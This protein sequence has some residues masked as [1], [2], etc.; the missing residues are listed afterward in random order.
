MK[1]L[2]VVCL[3]AS[4]AFSALAEDVS[5]VLEPD[6]AGICFAISNSCVREENSGN[7][8]MAIAATKLKH[9][10]SAD[11]LLK[12]FRQC[13][14]GLGDTPR[15]AVACER[16]V[17][18]MSGLCGT[19]ALPYVEHLVESDK[20]DG[21]AC[22][23][24]RQLIR[25]ERNLDRLLLFA[26]KLLDSGAGRGDSARIALYR[27]LRKLWKQA[28]DGGDH[29][30]KAKLASFFARRESL[31]KDFEHL[32]P[33]DFLAARRDAVKVDGLDWAGICFAISNSCVG[34]RHPEDAWMTIAA[35]KVKYK[36][37]EDQMLEAF[38]RCIEGLG[39]TLNETMACERIVHCMS[40]DCGTNALP[41]VEYLIEND[42][43]DGVVACAY[44]ELVKMEPSMDKKLLYAEKVLDLKS[45]HG[46][47]SRIVVYQE[48]RK[49]WNQTNKDAENSDK[50]KLASFFEGRRLLDKDFKYLAPH[51]FLSAKKEDG[52]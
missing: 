12:A 50:S 16:I 43:R 21:V 24:Y 41:Y 28:G 33:Q 52:R 11:Q 15:E 45:G 26:E 40:G 10:L 48:L 34:F 46:D 1:K 39:D 9:N 27:D 25:M 22:M 37:T 19:N 38:S 4:V 36:L 20:R 3:A 17:E 51:D 44:L 47:C 42:A 32:A 29:S 18:S 5:K 8:W 6:W 14:E 7:A 30:D 31:D 13:I 35:T 2:N 49:L 23:A